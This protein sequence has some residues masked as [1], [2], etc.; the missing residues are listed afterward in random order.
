MGDCRRTKLFCHLSF[1][2]LHEAHAKAVKAKI[3][4][5]EKRAA[6]KAWAAPPNHLTA[7]C[8]RDCRTAS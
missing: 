3:L 2:K 1:A 4:N 5:K 7:G 8:P 6:K